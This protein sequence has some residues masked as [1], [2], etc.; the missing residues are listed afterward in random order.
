VSGDGIEM[1]I[2]L[3]ANMTMPKAA[4][5]RCGVRG[6]IHRA[7]IDGILLRYVVCSCASTDGHD[8]GDEDRS[9]D[10]SVRPM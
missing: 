7:T 2:R 4:C 6:E 5:S 8:P 3:W 9:D 1:R 10:M